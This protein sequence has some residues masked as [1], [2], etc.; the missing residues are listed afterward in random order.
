M[1]VLMVC[2]LRMQVMLLCFDSRT[3]LKGLSIVSVIAKNAMVGGD[4]GI[5]GYSVS[6]NTVFAGSAGTFDSTNAAYRKL[7]VSCV[8]ELSLLPT[9]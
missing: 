3:V 8:E 9:F 7:Y 4:P 2:K 6:A 5:A 1:Q